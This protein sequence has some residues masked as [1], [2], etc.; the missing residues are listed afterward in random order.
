[1]NARLMVRVTAPTVAVSLLLL[2]VGAVAAWYMKRLQKESSDFL[3]VN[4]ASVRAAEEIEIG[5]REAQIHLYKFLRSGGRD[6]LDAITAIRHETDRWMHEADRLSDSPRENELMARAK[7]GYARFFSEFDQLTEQSRPGTT[8][9]T[10]DVEQLIDRVLTE[11]LLRPVHEYLDFNEDVVTETSKLNQTQT[12]RMTL[13]LLLLGTSGAVAGL[14]AGFGIA[15]GISRSI[16]QLSVPIRDVAG[17]LNE[18]VGPIT[19]SA[20][21]SLEQVDGELRKMAHRIGTVVERLQQSQREVLRTEQLAAVG[22]LAAGM[23]HE[24]RNPLMSM[25]LLVQ[26]AAERYQLGTLRARDLTQLEEVVTRLERSLQ[27][28]LDFAKPQQPA[29]TRF[30]LAEV[31]DQTVEL[32]SGRAEQQGVRV[33]IELSDPSLEIEADAGQVCQVL[34]NLLLNALDATPQGGSVWVHAETRTPGGADEDRVAAPR[35]E[36]SAHGV[37]IRVVDSGSGLPADLGDRIFDPFV[38]SKETGVGL[39]LTI[40]KRI[41]NSH[42][43]KISA[44]NW[45]GGGTAVTVWLPPPTTDASSGVGAA[46]AGCRSRIQ[47]Q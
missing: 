46:T 17:K 47:L 34:V 26:S 7:R 6:H 19:V 4:M 42:G 1:M 10:E 11:E 13:V 39:G 23:A 35:D 8:G 29:K 30:R 41:V 44:A 31:I 21:G 33:E 37:T 24:L 18:V 45:P 32:I 28:L 12:D 25:K 22:Q 36:S 43:G 2:A 16:V 38:S 3:A 15:R 9:A 40:S 20:G 14:L 5:L 27:T